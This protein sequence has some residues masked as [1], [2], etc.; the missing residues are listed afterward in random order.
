MAVKTNTKINGKDYFRVT[1][2]V[3]ADND[4]NSVRK[5][6]YGKSKKEAE[7][8]RDEYMANVNNGLSIDYD[9]IM[10]KDAFVTWLETVHKPTIALSTYTNYECI[11]RLH[12]NPSDSLNKKLTEIKSID[13]LNFY[14]TL[15]ER[16]SYTRVRSIHVLILSFFKYALKSDLVTKNPLIAVSLHKDDTIKKQVEA[17]TK[18]EIQKIIQAGTKNPDN[19]VFYFALATGLRQGEILALTQADIDLKGK[20]VNISKSIRRMRCSGEMTDLITPPKTKGSIRKIPLSDNVLAILQRHRRL[21]KEK[22]LKAGITFNQ[23]SPFFSSSTCG[24]ICQSEIIAAFYRLQAEL[25]IEQK[26]FHALRHTFCTLLHESGVSLKT[27]S[28]LM[29]HANI[30]TTAQIYT[31]VD[32]NEK[33]KAITMLSSLI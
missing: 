11:V 21:E 7:A 3:G 12:I 26:K 29:G 8:K 27:A 17:F 33:A 25:G 4:G 19:L 23:N 28:V 32:K 10:F 9:K 1:A 14:N 13:I 18:S 15:Y 20:T 22:H 31:H 30:N 16:L 6:F 2:T 24:H 5:Q